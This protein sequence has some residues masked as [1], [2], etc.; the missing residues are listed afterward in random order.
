M[1]IVTLAHDVA[2]SRV[3]DFSFIFE[4]TTQLLF[5]AETFLARNWNA[6]AAGMSVEA[7]MEDAPGDE[8]GKAALLSELLKRNILVQIALD[9]RPL[10][11]TRI[12]SI[13]LA[14]TKFAVFC[15]GEEA[16]STVSALFDEQHDIEPGPADF[17]IIV[18]SGDGQIAINEVGDDEFE[19]S[20]FNEAAPILRMLMTE[21]VLENHD[22][23]SLH[24]AI[25]DNGEKTALILGDS[26]AGKSV[27]TTFLAASGYNAVCDDV[28][29]V[30]S[31]GAVEGV[32]LPFTYKCEAWTLLDEHL[33]G[34]VSAQAFDRSDHKTVKYVPIE[35]PATAPVQPDFIFALDRVDVETPSIECINT[36][37]AMQ[38]LIQSGCT[39]DDRM[40]KEVFFSLCSLLRGAKAFRLRYTELT[41]GLSL[42]NDIFGIEKK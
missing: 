32:R 10:D 35:E 7:L 20:L 42:V 4:E 5:S 11:V 18:R 23:I 22:G 17:Q 34:L 8:G 9:G 21:C 37:D 39:E 33:P 30:D 3:H 6:L 19:V 2:L 15:E 13:D 1:H 16:E 26:G 25:F 36:V 27:L 40:S 28:A 31:T 14:G 24:S 29:V 38:L 41:E 12:R